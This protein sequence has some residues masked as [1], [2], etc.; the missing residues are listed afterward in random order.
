MR[1][2]YGKRYIDHIGAFSYQGRP[3]EA[4][5]IKSTRSTPPDPQTGLPVRAFWRITVGSEEF[6]A[7]PAWPDDREGEVRERIKQWLGK[8]LPRAGSSGG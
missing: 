6:D 8:N 5:V 7:F 4:R 3:V 1:R 2:D